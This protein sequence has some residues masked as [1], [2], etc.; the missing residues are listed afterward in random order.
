MLNKIILTCAVTTL[1]FSSF[2]ISPSILAKEN[3]EDRIFIPIGPSITCDTSH[4]EVGESMSCGGATITLESSETSEGSEGL[5][6]SSEAVVTPMGP[7]GE[8]GNIFNKD[9]LAIIELLENNGKIVN[10]LMS[11]RATAFAYPASGAVNVAVT[12]LG[13]HKWETTNS[14]SADQ[15]YRYMIELGAR[16]HYFRDTYVIR[17]SPNASYSGRATSLLTETFFNSGVFHVCAKTVISD[18]AQDLHC[19]NVTIRN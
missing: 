15:L 12:M 16:G 3:P 18:N 17:I 14:S 13:D 4:L 7:L 10:Q 8:G 11:S 19:N 5:M 1:T 9:P 6:L 2:F